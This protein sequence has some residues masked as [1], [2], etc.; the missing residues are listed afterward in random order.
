MLPSRAGEPG[1][2]VDFRA[3]TRQKLSPIGQERFMRRTITAQAT[4]KAG[5]S[6]PVRM[7][8]AGG[9]TPKTTTTTKTH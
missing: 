7:A 8:C 1:H 5:A 4:T 9:M 6:T 2:T 3:D